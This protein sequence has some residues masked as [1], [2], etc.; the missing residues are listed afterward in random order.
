MACGFCGAVRI[1]ARQITQ[2]VA[3]GGM[4]LPKPVRSEQG[5]RLPCFGCVRPEHC[6]QGRVGCPA[7][8]ARRM[9]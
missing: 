4:P 2:W 1:G 6:Q 7:R 3:R 5:A 8:L 9:S